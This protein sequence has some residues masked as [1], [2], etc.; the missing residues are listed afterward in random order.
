MLN[1]AGAVANA[2][3]NATGARLDRLPLTWSSLY[4]ALGNRV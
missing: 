3:A 4:R 1:A 2:L